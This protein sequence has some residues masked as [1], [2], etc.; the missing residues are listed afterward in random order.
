PFL[1]P[2]RHAALPLALSECP[3]KTCLGSCAS[4]AL[5][6]A[7]KRNGAATACPAGRLGS[8]IVQAKPPAQ[9]ACGSAR[10]QDHD[11]LP[12]LQT[13]LGLDLSELAQVGLDALQEVVADLLVGHLAPAEPQG[14]L[15]LVPF[16]EE[17]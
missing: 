12:A 3:R 11:H 13:R 14:D 10:G 6:F 17:A 16:V 4:S 7:C 8:L 9:A 1:V 2:A 5:V 15:D